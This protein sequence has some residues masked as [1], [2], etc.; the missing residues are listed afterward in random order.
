M[1]IFRATIKTCPLTGS[2]SDSITFRQAQRR[3][4]IEKGWVSHVMGKGPGAVFSLQGLGLAADL[5]YGL[6]PGDSL[7]TVSDS[8]GGG[9]TRSLSWWMPP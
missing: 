5:R 6:L 2:I 3:T 9:L 8:L 4:E 1:N 7:E